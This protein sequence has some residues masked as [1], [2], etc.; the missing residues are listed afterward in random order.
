[1]NRKKQYSYKLKRWLPEYEKAAGMTYKWAQAEIQ[2]KSFVHVATAYVIAPVLF[3]YVDWLLADA[4]YRKIDCLYFLS[5]DGYQML[6]IAKI[7]C[8]KRDYN[9]ELRYLYCSRY[10]LQIPSNR[11]KFD[12]IDRICTGGK[13]VSYEQIL[14][15][16]GLT[17]KEIDFVMLKDGEIEQKGKPLSYQRVRKLKDSLEKNSYFQKCVLQHSRETYSACIEYLRQEGLL[18]N[19]HYAIV[20]SGWTGGMQD[21][22]QILLRSA[23]YKEELE[24]YYFG[25]YELPQGKKKKKYHTFYFQPQGY[26]KRKV[27]FN[28]NLF[29]VLFS[30][31]EG[32][33]M[34]Y[35]KN[36]Q[37]YEPVLDRK[38][39]NVKLYDDQIRV[40]Q[41]FAT[42]I[43]I[44]SLDTQ[45]PDRFRKILAHGLDAVIRMFMSNPSQEEAQYYGNYFFSDHVRESG[46]TVLAEPLGKEELKAN[47]IFNRYRSM[48]KG[49]YV[50]TSFWIMGS[51]K[52]YNAGKF[53]MWWHRNQIQA[54]YYALYIRKD[55]KRNGKTK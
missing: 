42:Q 10:A 18:S 36:E 1:M 14:E 47:H 29:E 15:R 6:E 3:A 32:M 4:V 40:M 24:G 50:P 2:Q 8:E 43:E 37:K 13:K 31:P 51:L 27:M 21:M 35:Q 26:W 28:N 19:K 41:R 5:R 38:E 7:I 39:G 34:S 9:I 33:T 20:D 46:M 12:Y 54:Y 22:L 17:E 30:A 52:K 23:G 16:G 48:Q 11:L 55:I 49:E 45:Q 44:C 25:L 53:E